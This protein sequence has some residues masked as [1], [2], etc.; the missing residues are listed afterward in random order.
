VRQTLICLQRGA[1]ESKKFRILQ[2]EQL[3]CQQ[4]HSAPN[5]NRASQ[6]APSGGCSSVRANNDFWIGADISAVCAEISALAK[7]RALGC[8]PEEVGAFTPRRHS[9][10]KGAGL[11]RN[12]IQMLCYKRSVARPLSSLAKRKYPKN[13]GISINPG[14]KIHEY[15]TNTA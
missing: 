11:K 1:S 6:G 12:L 4:S 5:P 15:E 13:T 3:S 10:Q 9:A 2:C 7:T 8:M 14:I